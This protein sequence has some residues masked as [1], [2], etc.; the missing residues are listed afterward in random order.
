MVPE[1]TSSKYCLYEVSANITNKFYGDKKGA[2]RN[3]L[4]NYLTTRQ[5]DN[6]LLDN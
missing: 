4:I 3:E 1:R 5:D 6:F 2:L